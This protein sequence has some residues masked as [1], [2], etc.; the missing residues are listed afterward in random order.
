M[1]AEERLMTTLYDEHAAVLYAFVL[2]YVPDR[3]QA[4][5]VVQET[6]LRAWRHVDDLDPA[7]AEAR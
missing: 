4:S 3:D 6:L 7:R 5:D 1:N 2:R